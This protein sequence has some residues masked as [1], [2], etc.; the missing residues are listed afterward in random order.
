MPSSTRL[1][2]AHALIRPAGIADLDA[3]IR[4]QVRAEREVHLDSLRHAIDAIDSCVLVAEVPTKDDAGYGEEAGAELV[5]WAQTRHHMRLS[6]AAPVGHYLAG[7]TVSPDHRRRGIA[8]ALTSA[9][10]TWIATRAN[11]AYYV[12]NPR[13]RASIDLHSRWG[14]EEVLRA[15]VL[16]G[17]TFSGGI[18]LLMRARLGREAS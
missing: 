1:T 13:N 18:G 6:D 8:R 3:I 5:G 10:M 4:V 15:E 9:R 12:V 11:E 7:V 17:V 16:T 2:P 14:F